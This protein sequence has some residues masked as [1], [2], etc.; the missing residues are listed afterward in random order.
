MQS[1]NKISVVMVEVFIV[2]Q[3][4]IIMKCLLTEEYFMHPNHRPLDN[5]DGI[6]NK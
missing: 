2:L 4:F 1:F 6:T 3:L 5:I